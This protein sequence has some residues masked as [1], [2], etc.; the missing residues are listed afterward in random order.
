[1]GNT[2][3]RVLC[4]KYDYTLAHIDFL[5]FSKTFSTYEGPKLPLVLI[6]SGA[7]TFACPYRLNYSE[8]PFIK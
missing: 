1:M 4:S 6:F 3:L 8:D 5:D 7:G 2:S